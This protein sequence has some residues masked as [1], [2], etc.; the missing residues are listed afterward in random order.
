MP[1]SKSN[2]GTAP[3]PPGTNAVG[4]WWPVRHYGGPQSSPR[5]ALTKAVMLQTL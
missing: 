2:C 4:R 1:H 3:H 5:S